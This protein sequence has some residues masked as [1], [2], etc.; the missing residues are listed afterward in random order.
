M[1]LMTITPPPGYELAGYVLRYPNGTY[2]SVMH[3]TLDEAERMLRVHDE[4]G[5]TT[6]AGSRIEPAWAAVQPPTSADGAAR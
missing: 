1:D 2:S 5:W 4:M 3:H 6:L